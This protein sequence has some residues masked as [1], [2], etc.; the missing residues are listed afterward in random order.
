MKV[1]I[2]RV[3]K[4]ID[5]ISKFNNCT[6]EGISRFSFSKEDRMARDWIEDIC[7]NLGL[8]FKVDGVG[9]IRARYGGD[10]AP[11]LIG[12]HIDSVKNGGK[13]DGIVGVIGALEVLSVMVEENYKPLRPIELIIFAEEEGSNFGTTMVGSK[14]LI[15]KL[16]Y[17][18]L[19]QLH[20]DKGLSALKIM[21]DFS[22]NPLDMKNSILKSG[23]IFA[24]VELHIEQGIVLEREGLDL[25]VVNAIA[26]MTTLDVTVTGTS[27]HAGS[28]PMTMRNDALVASSE[29]FLEIE[30]IA[31]SIN[32]T[33]VATVGTIDLKPNMPNVI[34][35]KV[36]FTIDIRDIDN[37]S[38][39]K[40]ED[41]IKEFSKTISKKR[42]V[43]I[44]FE[45]IG[46]SKAIKLSDLVINEITKVVKSTTSSWMN[47]HSGAV[48]D[49]AMIAEIAPVG[50]IF[51]PSR[52]GISHNKDEYT[53]EKHIEMGV[54]V[55]LDT[56]IELS[57]K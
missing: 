1:N 40:A 8:T 25:G 32:P 35:G 37:D 22:L 17:N 53:D 16:S 23:D 30:K 19:N 14:S 26:G 12:S 54:Q 20:N 50:M 24:M 43:K 42:N 21:E 34:P 36:K 39:K 3:M 9:N 45:T 48:H 15:G 31:K 27:N 13:Y 52:N 33:T 46:S 57:Q 44:D 51:V 28:T 47:M 49:A 41:L 10:G 29:L 2:S 56:A 5:D 18:D 38:I 4:R 6:G 55:L 7:N 11:I